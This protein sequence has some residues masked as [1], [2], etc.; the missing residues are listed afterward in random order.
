MNEMT[1]RKNFAELW[2]QTHEA[3]KERYSETDIFP[4]IGPGAYDPFK[5]RF[6]L[7]KQPI[8][9]KPPGAFD[10]SLPQALE[11]TVVLDRNRGRLQVEHLR[12][13]GQTEV[14]EVTEGNSDQF[15]FT[16]AGREVALGDVIRRIYGPIFDAEGIVA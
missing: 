14:F 11:T 9:S 1:A 8:W 7:R 13:G 12:L 15:S 5:L 2:R 4:R 3:L 6:A 16:S 10:A